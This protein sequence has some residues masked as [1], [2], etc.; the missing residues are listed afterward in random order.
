MVLLQVQCSIHCTHH[1]HHYRWSCCRYSA[2]YTVHTILITIDGPVAGEDSFAWTLPY[3][4]APCFQWG[5]LPCRETKPVRIP[6]W[7]AN[8]TA[9]DDEVPDGMIAKN[10]I[11]QLQQLIAARGQKPPSNGGMSAASSDGGMSA[12]SS[13]GGMSAASSDGGMSAASSDGGMSAASSAVGNTSALQPGRPWFLA[14]GFHK[15]HLPHFA[16]AHYFSLYNLSAVDMPAV[17]NSP[18]GLSQVVW[19]SENN[20]ELWEYIDMYCVVW[21]V[22]CILMPSIPWRCYLYDIIRCMTPHSA[23]DILQVQQLLPLPSV[24]DYA[25]PF[26]AGGRDQATEV[27]VLC[28]RVI[29]RR[30]GGKGTERTGSRCES[31]CVYS[32]RALGRSCTLD[33]RRLYADHAA[34][35]W[36]SQKHEH[37]HTTGLAH[38]G[39][40]PLGQVHKLRPRYECAVDLC[41]ASIL[42]ACPRALGPC[43]HAPYSREY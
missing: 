19:A 20:H 28:V 43:T 22:L 17:P 15:P 5:S 21:H 33:D 38:R 4:H 7:R 8:L 2:S 1:T 30:A 10:A 36:R 23:D 42:G 13:D 14:V 32:H 26:A 39:A 11:V 41:A 18:I 40:E 27:S 25:E 3:F 35:T 34:H 31:K 29:H 9:T 12:A 24:R 37:T 16:P 6:S